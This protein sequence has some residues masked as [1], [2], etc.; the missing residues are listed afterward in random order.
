MLKRTLKNKK[1]EESVLNKNI[2]VFDGDSEKNIDNHKV[3]D[4]HYHKKD[5]FEKISRICIYL[6]T[7]LLPL[8]FVPSALIELGQAKMLILTLFVTISTI[9]LGVSIIYSGVVNIL[10]RWIY[11]PAIFISLITLL[12]S[13]FSNSY[14]GS[15]IGM[16]LETDSWYIISLLVLLVVIISCTINTKGRIVMLLS[17]LWSGFAVT[18][19]F[20][21]LRFVFEAIGLKS[22]VGFLSLGGLFSLTTLNTIG[23]WG[24]F[25]IFS[26]FILISLAITLDSVLLKKK[27]N[28]FFWIGYSLS[29]ILTIITSFIVFGFGKSSINGGVQILFPIISVVGFFALIFAISQLI[30]RYQNRHDDSIKFPLA[31]LIVMSFGILFMIFPVSINQHVNSV[32]N[33]P[34]ESMLNVR[35]DMIETSH[36][37][38]EILSSSFKNSL[39]GYGTHG[40]FM[41]RNNFRLESVNL[42]ELW[43]S[44]FQFGFGYLPTILINNGILGLL[45]WLS[46][47]F[48]LLFFGLRL[49]IK[50][51]NM[52]H[53]LR[54]ILS[55]VL[56]SYTALWL[57]MII[58]VPSA[59][60]VILTFL[61]TGILLAILKIEGVFT[62]TRLDFSKGRARGVIGVLIVLF[63]LI[64]MVYVSINWM[65]RV[66]AYTYSVK[67][68]QLVYAKDASIDTVPK[69][70][71]LLNKAMS[72]Y[73]SDVY[74]RAINNLAMIQVN[75]DFSSKSQNGSSIGNEKPKLATSTLEYLNLALS[76]GQVGVNLN[77][78]DFRNWIQFGST[79]QAIALLTE[80]NKAADGALQTFVQS[81]SLSSKH[82]L[83]YYM[84]ANL[85][86]LAGD[87]KNAKISVEQAI[88]LKSNFEEAGKIYNKILEGE[89]KSGVSKVDLT[90]SATSTVTTTS[91]ST[92]GVLKPKSKGATSSKKK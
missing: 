3:S 57:L 75:Y 15:I 31:S 54:Y 63:V 80:E 1:N 48:I 22:V 87:L 16:S 83:P 92:K 67:S 81:V 72:I 39:I 24:D 37:A 49:W 27:T 17:L 79:L 6:L 45:S 65:N 84:L 61:M 89:S 40:F 20:Q 11:I 47:I 56:I 5:I 9:S 13:I 69:A 55:W 29:L 64:A 90:E 41:A 33:V 18:A 58:N 35:P 88:K 91:T 60:I 25:G 73:P 46:L 4:S 71:D 52:D 12:S 53:S 86:L 34:M 50:N 66:R 77:P 82:P 28:R 30:R 19:I 43:N 51:K 32:L 74:S 2:E 21:L 7:F 10:S 14:R 38:K 62:E 26:G 36:I 68:M 59:S 78:N 42:S 23:S 70:I 76:S 44:D 85:Y 8:F